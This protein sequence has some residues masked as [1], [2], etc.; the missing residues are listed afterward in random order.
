[1]KLLLIITITAIRPR[2][3]YDSIV[4]NKTVDIYPSAVK[5]VPDQY[6][7]HKMCD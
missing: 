4:C 1:M 3:S 2:L 5:L 7:T 6:K